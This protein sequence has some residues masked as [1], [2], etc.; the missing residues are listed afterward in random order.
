MMLTMPAPM[1]DL[2]SCSIET[3]P[4]ARQDWRVQPVLSMQIIS[5]DCLGVANHAPMSRC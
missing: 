4:C 3:F 2:T 1:R 5:S